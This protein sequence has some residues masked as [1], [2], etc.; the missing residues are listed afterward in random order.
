MSMLIKDLPQYKEDCNRYARIIATVLDP[1]I[2][3]RLYSMYKDF[4]LKAESLD[5]SMEDTGMGFSALGVG[6]KEMIE[7]FKKV[8]LDIERFIKI[9]NLV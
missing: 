4:R 8:R 7:E 1:E 5:Q 2:K 9:S 6:H 3:S